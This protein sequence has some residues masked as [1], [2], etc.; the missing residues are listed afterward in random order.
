MKCVFVTGAN[1][2]LGTNL[3][4][5]LL[6]QGYEVKAFVRKKERFIHFQHKNLRINEGDILDRQLLEKEIGTCQYVVHVAAV[7]DQDLLTLND[8]RKINVQGTKNIVDACKAQKVEKLVYIGT[9]NTFGYGNLL[10]P[11]YE[12]MEMKK[13]FTKSLYAM[14]KM[15]AQSLVDRSAKTINITTIS[16]TFMLGAYDTKPSS[17][18]LI[19][20][21]LNK[22]VI[23]CPSG[24]KNFVHVKDVAKA[25]IKG[26][27]LKTSG[28]NFIVANE[29]MSY[30]TFFSKVARLNNQKSI[31]IVIPDFLLLAAGEA[32][33]IFRGFGIKTRLSRVNTKILTTKNYYT[34]FKAV[35]RLNLTFTPIDE[36]IRDA[37]DWFKKQKLV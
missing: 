2:L 25:V 15:E 27:E 18:E 17:G 35:S 32:G 33:E 16:P 14:S 24:G 4:L 8:Y 11:G 10:K 6:K 37:I 36:A 31:F 22:K 5:L 29:N 13:P 19:L 1:G 28:E 34:N 26:L 30:K 3:V 12:G 20:K 23:F 7:T 21:A 9:A